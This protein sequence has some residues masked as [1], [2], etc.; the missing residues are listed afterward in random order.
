MEILL[1]KGTKNF[2]GTAVIPVYLGDRKIEPDFIFNA[3]NRNYLNSVASRFDAS[4]K[5]SKVLYLPEQE[6]YGNFSVLFLGLGDKT[7]FNL[8][9]YSYAIRRAVRIAKEERIKDIAIS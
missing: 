1:N 8:K 3:K 4:D 9:K 6:K 5:F 2:N 7:K